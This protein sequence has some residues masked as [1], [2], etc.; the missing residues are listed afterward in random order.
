MVV[1]LFFIVRISARIKKKRSGKHV[2]NGELRDEITCASSAT[3]TKHTFIHAADKEKCMDNI[4]SSIAHST[5]AH[6]CH[7]DCQARGKWIGV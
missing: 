1:N 5:Y 2:F 3:D 4:V 6:V 7:A